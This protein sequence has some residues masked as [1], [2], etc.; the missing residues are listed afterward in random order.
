MDDLSVNEDIYSIY[1]CV[2]GGKDGILAELAAWKWLNGLHEGSAMLT[3][4][5]RREMMVY[6]DGGATHH[7]VNDVTLFSSSVEM[8]P[9]RRIRVANK[10]YMHA[11][12]VGA[13]H[14]VVEGADGGKRVLALR[15]VFFSAD[16]SVYLYS[17]NAGAKQFGWG[18][19]MDDDTGVLMN[20][21]SRKVEPSA[22][23]RSQTTR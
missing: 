13:V 6:I 15:N 16:A 5:G 9:P 8:N 23:V 17:V 19:Y 3:E 10:K 22:E 18:S 1:S 7:L 14:F 12:R 21:S 20:K 11:T 2:T 4:E